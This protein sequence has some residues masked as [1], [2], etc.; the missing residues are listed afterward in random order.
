MDQDPQNEAYWFHPIDTLTVT[1]TYDLQDWQ[2]VP[3][4]SS[5]KYLANACCFQEAHEHQIMKHLA[6]LYL[7]R[8][9]AAHHLR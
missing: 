6:K 2:N 8:S 7:A 1:K 9:W 5:L 3:V 4:V